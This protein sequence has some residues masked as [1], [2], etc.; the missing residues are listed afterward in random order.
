MV[1]ALLI[2]VLAVQARLAY[3]LYEL[4]QRPSATCFA[5]PC[6]ATPCK[7]EPCDAVC[8]ATP[9]EAQ[10]CKAEPALIPP[11]CKWQPP[12]PAPP[13]GMLA[14]AANAVSGLV[15]RPSAPPP[16][17]EAAPALLRPGRAALR[18]RLKLHADREKGK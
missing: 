10:A 12:P 8:H 15:S 4:L 6:G 17:L 18:A 14:R 16:A 9:C 7:A 2:V 3:W 1:I 5:Q 11:P 13:M